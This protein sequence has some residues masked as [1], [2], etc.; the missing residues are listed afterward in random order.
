MILAGV[1]DANAIHPRSVH[2]ASPVLHQG[3]VGPGCPW[4]RH[5]WQVAGG[6]L[7]QSNE[8]DPLCSSGGGFIIFL[9]IWGT[10]P[11]SC[12]NTSLTGAVSATL[13]PFWSL[14]LALLELGTDEMF[15]AGICVAWGEQGSYAR[16]LVPFGNEGQ[17][18]GGCTIWPCCIALRS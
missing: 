13:C 14:H 10:V 16:L 18:G 12:C 5:G 7:G 8:L 11:G 3:C 1:G 6:Y 15:L 9:L 17:L 4:C 2:V